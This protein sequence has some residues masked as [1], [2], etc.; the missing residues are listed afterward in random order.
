MPRRLGRRSRI[1]WP[2]QGLWIL[3]ATEQV[4]V[5]PQ[6]SIR[7]LWLSQRRAPE[8][9][10]PGIY[11]VDVLWSVFDAGAHSGGVLLSRDSEPG[12]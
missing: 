5:N 2:P 1:L 6:I 11:T 9:H 10:Y 7:R 12:L 8:A 3:G 4:H